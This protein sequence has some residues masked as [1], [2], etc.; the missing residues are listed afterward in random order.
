MKNNLRNSSTHS[1]LTNNNGSINSILDKH[2][3]THHPW[4]YRVDTA[5][6]FLRQYK[7]KVTEISND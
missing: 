4:L 1:L 2:I 5:L 3:V 7:G 6:N